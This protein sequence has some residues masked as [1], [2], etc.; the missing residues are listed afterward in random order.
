MTNIFEKL[1]IGLILFVRKLPYQY[2]FVRGLLRP[3]LNLA[4]F[5]KRDLNIDVNGFAMSLNIRS[6][7][8]QRALAFFPKQIDTVMLTYLNKNLKHGDIFIDL[9]AHAGYYS[10]VASKRL[11]NTGRVISIEADPFNIEYIQRNFDQNKCCSDSEIIA[12]AVGQSKEIL[13][14]SINENNRGSNTLKSHD[15]IPEN[16]IEVQVDSLKGWLD[17]VG[18]EKVSAIKLDI[19][20]CEMLALNSL[21]NDYPKECHPRFI[22]IEINS[23]FDESNLIKPFLESHGYREDIRFGDNYAFIKS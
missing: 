17:S 6:S 5:Y 13:K 21:I 11:D 12:G 2:R 22:L 15:Y 20:G 9:G 1:I 4:K 10:L 19:E 14:L 8:F 18:C 7:L 3:F 16:Y 23:Q